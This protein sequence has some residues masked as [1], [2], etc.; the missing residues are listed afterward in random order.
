MAEWATSGDG[1]YVRLGGNFR[2]EPASPLPDEEV[3]SEDQVGSDP[4]VGVRAAFALDEAEVGQMLTKHVASEPG[5]EAVNVAFNPDTGLA[6]LSGEVADPNL[7]RSA[8]RK[9]AGH[10]FVHGVRD[11]LTMPSMLGASL[12]QLGPA[13]GAAQRIYRLG[14]TLDVYKLKVKW[15]GQLPVEGSKWYVNVYLPGGEHYAHP[16]AERRPGGPTIDVVFDHS[17]LTAGGL[18]GDI[19]IDVG[20][21]LG[22][23]APLPSDRNL[24]SNL[25]GLRVDNT[26]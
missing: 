17:E 12:A 22:V 13:V 6:T 23:P 5:L 15:A 1:K 14:H 11:E 16:L 18:E 10:W 20:L 9:L 7:R 25:F 3:N 24:V 26:D 21:S 4:Y 19:D 8:S 2:T